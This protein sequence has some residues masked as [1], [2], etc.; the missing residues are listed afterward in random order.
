VPGFRVAAR[1]PAPPRSGPRP[2]GPPMVWQVVHWPFSRKIFSPAAASCSGVR[3][4][5][6]SDSSSGGLDSSWGMELA[7]QV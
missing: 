6:S 1:A 4:A 2:P 5:P 3:L 7:Y